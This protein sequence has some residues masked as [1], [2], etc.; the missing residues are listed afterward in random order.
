MNFL[1]RYFLTLRAL[2]QGSPSQSAPAPE[3]LLAFRRLRALRE[4]YSEETRCAASEMDNLREQLRAIEGQAGAIRLQLAMKEA[5][6]QSRA[7]EMGAQ[8]DQLLAL[9]RAQA[10]TLLRQFLDDIDTSLVELRSFQPTFMRVGSGG[11]SNAAS[12]QRRVRALQIARSRAEEMMTEDVSE[13]DIRVELDKM[14]R[15]LPVV[16]D[17]PVS[18]RMTRLLCD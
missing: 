11:L 5:A 6:T 1:T 4:Q 8:E 3:R 7:L 18:Q 16:L 9:I 15:S 14:E 10:P 17:E 13:S 2:F 12:L